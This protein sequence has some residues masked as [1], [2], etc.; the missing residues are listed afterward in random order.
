MKKH[1]VFESF[2]DFVNY[3]KLMEAETEPGKSAQSQTSPWS[4]N[5]DSGKFKKSEIT[6]EQIKKL[7]D[8]FQK[9][10]VPLLNNQNYIGQK[11][12]VSISAASSKVP[13]NPSGDVAKELKAAGYAPSNEGLC[14]ARGNTV[15]GIIKEML[16]K[17]FGQGME[18][19]EFDKALEKK[20]SLVNKPLP[21]IGPEYSRANGDNPDD[22]KYKDNQ[23]I[24]A[25]LTVTGERLPDERF[26]SCKMD[27]QFSGGQANAANGFAGYDKTVFLRAKAGQQMEIFF[28]P[29]TVPDAILFSYS[30][31]EVKLSPFSGTYGAIF[32]KGPYDKARED[33]WNKASAEGKTATAKK[34][35]IGGKD[36]LVIDYKEYI[37]N[38]INKGGALVN[39][40]ESKL[41]SLGLG[42]IK[43]ICPE[44]FDSEGKIEVYRNKDLSQIPYSSGDVSGGALTY[45]LIKG[46]K[47]KESPKADT[48]SLSIK[49][50]KNAVRDAVTLVAFSPIAGTAFKIRTV[51]S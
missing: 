2:E 40:I 18:K 26:I 25:S 36:Y 8:D 43:E 51:C 44:F 31:K 32:V 34:M 15:A 46:G 29:I 28:D 39:A 27:K 21:N 30:G 16:Y 22:Q 14:K 6:P 23:F 42:K 38:V 12:V 33:S 47:L 35:N 50:T 3:Q 4:F 37:N 20:M 24:S 41:K 19:A 49:I 1:F 17:Q 7:E 11:L 5:F 10:I 45:D 48:T 13:V 9:K